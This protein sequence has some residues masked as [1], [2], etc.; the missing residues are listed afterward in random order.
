MEQK[1]ANKMEVLGET[2]GHIERALESWAKKRGINRNIFAVLHTLYRDEQCTQK[3][4]CDDWLL[5][6]QTISTVCQNLIT[7]GLLQVSDRSNDKREKILQLTEAG[8]AYTKP[9]MD[10]LD[11]IETQ[12]FSHFDE[13]EMQKMLKQI[14]AIAERFESLVEDIK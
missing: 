10:E 12:I 4:I 1:P 8:M 14:Q 13:A 2:V 3:Q 7:Q 9:L 11:H 5:P 6:K